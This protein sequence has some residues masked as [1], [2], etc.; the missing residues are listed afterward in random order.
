MWMQILKRKILS[1]FD[2][3]WLLN[4]LLLH[5]TYIVFKYFSASK[6]DLLK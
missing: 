2:I 6:N 3:V 5:I 4:I 1:F